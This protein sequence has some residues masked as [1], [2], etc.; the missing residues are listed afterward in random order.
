ME[1]K[2]V[3]IVVPPNKKPTGNK[4]SAGM[5]KQKRSGKPMFGT[6]GFPRNY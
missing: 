6:S 3:K 5:T 2:P 4:Q 1:Q